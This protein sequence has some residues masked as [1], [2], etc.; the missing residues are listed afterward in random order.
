MLYDRM[1]REGGWNYGN[2]RI[3]G[4]ELHPYPLTTSLALI[5]LQDQAGRDENKKSIT[6]LKHT[7]A[8]EKSALSLAFAMLC[9]DLYGESIQGQWANLM[10]MDIDDTFAKNIKTISAVLMAIQ[11]KAGR[12]VFRIEPDKHASAPALESAP[13][14]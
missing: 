6:Y 4:E 12:N 8:T 9:L 14:V 1:C 5:A 2:A 7:L 11:I 13:L 3:L 10:A